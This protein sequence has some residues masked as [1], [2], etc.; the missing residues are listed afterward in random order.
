MVAKL[1]EDYAS[2]ELEELISPDVSSFLV[3]EPNEDD[4]EIDEDDGDCYDNCG[5]G[6]NESNYVDKGFLHFL[7]TQQNDSSTETDWV[8]EKNT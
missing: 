7:E 4:E 1:V 3:N 8:L 5:E 2:R 6:L